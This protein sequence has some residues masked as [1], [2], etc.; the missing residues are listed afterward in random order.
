MIFAITKTTI[1]CHPSI[2]L[3]V[4]SDLDHKV[5]AAAAALEPAWDGM[6]ESPETRVW[7]IE[8]FHVKAW[9]T[10][11]HGQFHKGDS[12]LILHTYKKG[13]SDALHHDIHMWI[14]SESSQDEYG[15]AAYKMVEAD[16]FLGGVPVQ[17]RQVQGHEAED[18]LSYFDALEYLDGGV[19]SGFNHVEPDVE[20]PVLFRIKGKKKKRTLTQVPMTK[21]SL[22]EGDSFILF[23]GKANVWCWHGSSVRTIV[24]YCYLDLFLM[25]L[26]P[27]FLLLFGNYFTCKKLQAKP[28][29]KADSNVWAETMC[30]LGTVTVLDQGQGDEDCDEFWKYLG[31]GEIQPADPSADEGLT[32]F[33]PL[34]YRVDGDLSKDLE[35]VAEGTP[36]AKTSRNCTCLKKSDLVEGDV[37]LMDSGWE[38]YVWMGSGCDRSEKIAAMAAADKYA[39]MDPRTLEL[40]VHIIKSGNETNTFLSYFD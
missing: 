14:G 27:K 23:G 3:S 29:E 10:E 1:Y 12:Y 18:F 6:G 2:Y 39:K 28:L 19:K 4:G 16:D 11:R 31:D 38:I 21:S 13:D 15:T 32:E 35:K 8:Q 17:H 37:F 24:Q 25:C 9:P 36:I 34:L 26:N 20:N 7:R 22:N 30:T 33:A 5:K 40:P